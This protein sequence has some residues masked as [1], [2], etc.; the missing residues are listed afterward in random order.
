MP[1]RGL[2]AAG[3]FDQYKRNI[4]YTTLVQAFGASSASSYACARP[5]CA[6]A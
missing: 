2:F 1:P 6:L 4:P 5:S 3:K